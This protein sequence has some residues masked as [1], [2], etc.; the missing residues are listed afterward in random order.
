MFDDDSS[1]HWSFFLRNREAGAAIE[2]SSG[3][4]AGAMGLSLPMLFGM[5]YADSSTNGFSVTGDYLRFQDD[6]RQEDAVNITAEWLSRAELIVVRT[7]PAGSVE[8]TVEIPGFEIRA[9]PPTPAMLQFGG[10]R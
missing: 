7:V 5:S 10:A 8:R 3:M 2:G 9:A 4:F 1:S 6:N